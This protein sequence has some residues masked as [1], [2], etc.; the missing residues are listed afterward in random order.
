MVSIFSSISESIFW[1]ESSFVS[2]IAIRSEWSSATFDPPT[3]ESHPYSVMLPY[4]SDSRLGVMT[5]VID[6]PSVL[7]EPRANL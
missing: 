1:S 4:L 5:T 2:R 3:F 6:S 7:T